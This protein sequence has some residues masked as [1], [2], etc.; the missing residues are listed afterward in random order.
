MPQYVK[1]LSLIPYIKPYV[2]APVKEMEELQKKMADD[3]DV[4][5]SQYDALEEASDAIQALP[6]KGDLEEKK[7]VM[8]NAK[9]E[10]EAAQKAGD[11]QNRGR[12]VRKAFNNLK[13]GYAPIKE[14]VTAWEAFKKD[15]EESVKANRY[16]QEYANKI[17]T[18]TKNQ[19]KIQGGLKKSG[20]GTYAGISPYLKQY[21]NEVDI[22][23]EVLK[24]INPIL[25]HADSKA[26]KIETVNG[27]YYVTTE[28]GVEKVDKDRLK[29]A[30]QQMWAS[31]KSLQAYSRDNALLDYY[32]NPEQAGVIKQD[33]ISK[34][35]QMPA[36]TKELLQQELDSLKQKE[37]KTGVKY[38]NILATAESNLRKK[39]Y[40]K[41][42]N[43]KVVLNEL[44]N[45]PDKDFYINHKMQD[46]LNKAIGLGEAYSYEKLND[47]L[48]LDETSEY[49]KRQEL[50]AEKKFTSQGDFVTSGGATITD[51]D[52]VVNN[53]QTTAAKL[54]SSAV[55]SLSSESKN[56][57]DEFKTNLDY[58]QL[59]SLATEI[60]KN[61][62]NIE[63]IKTK[64]GLTNANNDLLL[65]KL[66]NINESFSNINKSIKELRQLKKYNYE[67]NGFIKT[68]EII[69]KA[70]SVY[71]I[72]K[73][74]GSVETEKFLIDNNINSYEDL[75]TFYR[76]KESS[77]HLAEQTKAFNS[78]PRAV[79]NTV[80]DSNKNL[81]DSIKKS[82]TANK[83]KLDNYVVDEYVVS[84]PDPKSSTY[85][86]E[87]KITTGISKNIDGQT[88][89]GTDIDLDSYMKE[90][91]DDKKYELESTSVVLK[92]FGGNKKIRATLKVEGETKP[93]HVYLN[94]GENSELVDRYAVSS[95]IDNSQ[96]KVVRSMTE[97]SYFDEKINNPEDLDLIDNTNI[98]DVVLT[99]KNRDYHVDKLDNNYYKVYYLDENNQKIPLSKA[100]KDLNTV[101][102]E[103]GKAEILD[104]YKNLSE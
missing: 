34:I 68:P 90:K 35:V 86:L 87:Q 59:K 29:N 48:T 10:I 76:T 58:K 85:Q 95:Y 104:V 49:K 41:E 70:K 99:G 20:D 16:S 96:P 53:R 42:E 24:A 3:Y 93:V 30:V 94:L 71:T 89:E 1:E 2:A 25:S 40:V 33:K 101:R 44:L 8:D 45:T 18:A 43:K 21:A 91:Y 97:Q 26:S 65:A 83:N 46:D 92:G 36:I 77:K 9:K 5:A 69:T 75:I 39:G 79:R 55:S 13:K 88:I 28:H 57:N 100:V 66:D 63:Q 74:N 61:P 7:L 82:V 56:F 81:Y 15:V 80:L 98:K 103:I 23:E 17:L 84:N 11:Y 27:D 19:Y 60:Q 72:L 37:N 52:A 31:N 32:I 62:N 14:Q 6:F 50:N 12:L 51:Q 102:A 22:N 73:N 67:V 38:K 78:L 64:Y 4:V 54:N 47:A